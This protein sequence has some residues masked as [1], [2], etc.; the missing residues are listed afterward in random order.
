[1]LNRIYLSDEATMEFGKEL[2]QDAG[3]G[4]ISAAKRAIT[5]LRSTGTGILAGVQLVSEI[6]PSLKANARTLAC[7]QSPNLRDAQEM[8][9]MLGL[10]ESEVATLQKLPTGTAYVLSEGFRRAVLVRVPAYELGPYP[11]DE[12]VASHMAAELAQLQ[13]ETIYSPL[14]D[15][16]PVID[17]REWLGEPKPPEPEAVPAE[18]PLDP[19]LK[20]RFFAEH[21]L[22]LQDIQTAPQASVTDHYRTLGWSAGRG[23]RVKEQ[24]LTMGLIVSHR[25]KTASGRP[26]EVLA[27]T[28]LGE[29]FLHEAA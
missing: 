23:H 1:M 14:P 5:Q 6:D 15:K 22:L 7:F 26:R 24:L 11:S 21:R 20:Q 12:A 9:R 13:A 4:Y 8:Q 3:S 17:C 16:D 25:Q 18:V 2:S 29:R 19:A 10:P 28:P 27:L